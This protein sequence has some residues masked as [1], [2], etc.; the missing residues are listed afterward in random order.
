MK[1][2][3]DPCV[4]GENTQ[5]YK[6]NIMESFTLFYTRV[7]CKMGNKFERTVVSLELFSFHFKPQAVTLFCLIKPN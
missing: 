4:L 5:A 2:N 7:C 6:A 3:R 1:S